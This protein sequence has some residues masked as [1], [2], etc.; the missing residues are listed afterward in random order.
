MGPPLIDAP[1]PLLPT[2]TAFVPRMGSL[3]RAWPPL[4]LSWLLHLSFCPTG[5]R[6][7]EELWP[8][9]CPLSR[10]QTWLSS[11]AA[12]STGS[13]AI[14]TLDYFEMCWHQPCLLPHMLA[15]LLSE[16]HTTQGLSCLFWPF[17]LS[18]LKHSGYLNICGFQIFLARL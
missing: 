9:R 16:C 13:A 1:Q 15:S 5:I 17:S 8:Q 14:S 7:S 12:W 2:E 4:L 3:R 18:A 6:G 10:Y 11:P